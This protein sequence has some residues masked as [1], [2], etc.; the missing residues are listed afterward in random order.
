MNFLTSFLNLNEMEIVHQIERANSYPP[1][2]F[3]LANILEKRPESIFIYK[4]ENI[5][6][7]FIDTS[8]F[9]RDP[10]N[11]YFFLFLVVIFIIYKIFRDPK[12]T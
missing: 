12:K 10:K 4:I 11:I 1:K 5:F 6:F 7:N 2:L 3:F 9:S 8:R